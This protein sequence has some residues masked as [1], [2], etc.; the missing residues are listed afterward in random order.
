MSYT[1]KN[2]LESMNKITEEYTILF[3]TLQKEREERALIEKAQISKL[4]ELTRQIGLLASSCETNEKVIKKQDEQSKMYKL[5]QQEYYSIKEE[6]KQYQ[7]FID[8]TIDKI[9]E[10]MNVLES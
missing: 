2:S 1:L 7:I 4:E 5:L 8:D 3:D 10:Q 9:K 6:Y